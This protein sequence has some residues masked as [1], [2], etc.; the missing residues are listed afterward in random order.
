MSER[1]AQCAYGLRA[2]AGVPPGSLI[3]I[4]IIIITIV[5]DLP[6]RF[7]AKQLVPKTVEHCTP[8]Y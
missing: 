3:I 8:P 7:N 2:R 6:L 1:G 5:S 4:I